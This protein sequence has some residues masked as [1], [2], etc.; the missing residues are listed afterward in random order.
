MS[1]ILVKEN[2]VLGL[3]SV[4]R[5]ESIV[6]AGKKLVERGY[7]NEGYVDA[8]LEREKISPTELG[9]GIAI[10]HGNFN[11]VIKEKILL[12]TLDKPILWETEQVDIIFCLAI[13]FHDK[14]KSKQLISNVYHIIKSK[15]IIDQI[16]NTTNINKLKSVIEHL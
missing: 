4:S 9:K 16:R 11:C 2:I 7:V 13:N 5:E 10:P 15:D 6:L 8:M 3:D 1:N 14:Q 12:I